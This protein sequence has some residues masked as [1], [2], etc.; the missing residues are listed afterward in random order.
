M[1]IFVDIAEER[2]KRNYARK[3][4]DS[5]RVFPARVNIIKI[6]ISIIW[7]SPQSSQTSGYSESKE[8]D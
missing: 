7:F 6:D 4:R 5:T 3:E 1:L 2:Y 8:A